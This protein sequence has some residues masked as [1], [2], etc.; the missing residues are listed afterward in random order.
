MD[1]LT[2]EIQ[3][4]ECDKEP[5]QFVGAIQNQGCMLILRLDEQTNRL[6]ICAASDNLPAKKWIAAEDVRGLMGA[7]IF[8]IFE[9]RMANRIVTLV[10]RFCSISR[11]TDDVVPNRNF[12]M[13]Q[14]LCKGAIISTSQSAVQVCC[15]VVGC[16]KKN[17]FILELEEIEEALL[18]EIVTL[19]GTNIL[20][21]GDIV[22]RV[23]SA[24]SMSAA[25]SI[26]CDAVLETLPGFDRGMVYRFC[27]DLS[28]EV[29]YENVLHPERVSSSY[30]NLRFPAG[31]I[32][33]AA[34]KLYVRN[35]VRFISDV[36][37]KNSR[38]VSYGDEQ[39]DLTMSC[40]RACSFPCI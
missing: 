32:P 2:E 16:S 9:E 10:N 33:L 21:V 11:N 22:G 26:F 1:E 15:S 12:A 23:R 30:L 34:R 14:M 27:D 25:L 28:G 36:S 13:L 39:F 20:C 8:H 5:L 19:P 3:L 29:V 4:S 17:T 38:L 7:D 18:S 6:T 24:E 31:D 37:A 35:P 40:L